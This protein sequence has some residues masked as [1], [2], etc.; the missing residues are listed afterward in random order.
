MIEFIYTNLLVMMTIQH[1]ECPVLSIYN[2]SDLIE[3]LTKGIEGK[4][5]EVDDK[6]ISDD[7]GP[8]KYEPE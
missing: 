7:K 1:D 6:R 2:M 3:K 5:P 4:V 8:E